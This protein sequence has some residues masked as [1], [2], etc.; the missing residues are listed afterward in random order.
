MKK[1]LVYIA[2][3]LSALFWGASYVMTKELFITEEYI[4]VPI[5]ITLRLLVVVVLFVPL[6]LSM[7]KLERIKKGDLRWFLILAAV[8]PFIHSMFEN[9][10]VKWTSSSLSAIMVA[11][12]PVF[13]PFVMAALYKEKIRRNHVVGIMLSVAG[14]GVMLVGGDAAFGGSLKGIL[15]LVGAVALSMTYTLLV[16]KI[17]DKYDPLSVTM[18][19]NIFG[20][21]Y[22]L[23]VMFVTSSSKLPLL[24]WSPTMILLIAGLGIFCS[25]LAYAF[26]NYGVQKAGATKACVFVNGIPVV[27]MLTAVMIGQELLNVWKVLGMAVVIFGI[28]LAQRTEKLS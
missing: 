24:S 9:A 25:M 18:Y 4:T 28:F 26:Y 16:A 8:E 11:T 5:I 23:P 7:H 21:I 3:A 2:L 6:L 15:C 14:I 12:A 19:Q 13:I 17:M 27:T 10:G 20:L 22:Y 1:V